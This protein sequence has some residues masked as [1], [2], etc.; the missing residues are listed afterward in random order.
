MKTTNQGTEFELSECIIVADN[1]LG[2][3]I[4]LL[5]NKILVWETLEYPN[6][7][8]REIDR[9]DDEDFTNTAIFVG[10]FYL[11]QHKLNYVI[12]NKEVL[13]YLNINNNI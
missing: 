5:P 11:N 9:D 2:E 1:E 12:K 4:L 7:E 3:R 8:Y 13:N 6:Y 10:K